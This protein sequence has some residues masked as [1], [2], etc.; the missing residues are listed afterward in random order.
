MSIKTNAGKFELETSEGGYPHWTNLSH[1][2]ETI[3][4]LHHTELADLEY[5]VKRQREL[6]RAAAKHTNPGEI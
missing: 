5:A 2:G 3:V 4:R 6:L 1:G